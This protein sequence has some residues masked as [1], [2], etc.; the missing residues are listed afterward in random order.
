[1]TCLI[2]SLCVSVYAVRQKAA[3]MG[4]DSASVSK[5]ESSEESECLSCYVY[6]F[7]FFGGGGCLIIE[8]YNDNG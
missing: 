7:V 5:T 2:P 4:P 1:M 3:V 8:T 6:I